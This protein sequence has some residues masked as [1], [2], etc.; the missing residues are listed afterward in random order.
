MIHLKT[1]IITIGTE[2]LLGEIVNTNAQYLAEQ[3]AN[4][5]LDVYFQTVVGDNKTRF[6]HALEI[7]AQRAKV[8]VCTGGLGPTDD[9]LTKESLAEYLDE[10]LE[11]DDAAKTKIEHFFT[12]RNVFMP[13]NNLKQ[14]L[15]ISGDEACSLANDN[16][17]AIG[18][19]I[20]KNGCYFILLPG[21]PREMKLMFQSYAVPWILQKATG[22]QRLESKMLCF[23]GIGESSVA[24][25]LHDLIKNQT[26]PSIATY[27]KE[28]EVLVRI[29]SKNVNQIAP[30]EAQIKQRLTEY[31]YAEQERTLEQV[32]IE[33][34]LEKK[35]R[36]AVA[37]SCTGG[38]LSQLI[39]SV[40]GSSA[41]LHSAVVAYTNEAKQDL[42][43]ITR[44]LL[45]GEHAPGA[46]SEQTA[47]QMAENM[48]KQCG[49][50]Y[51]VAVTGVAGPGES[52]GKP[53]G[54]V[55][56]AV[57][58]NGKSTEVYEYRTGGTR[59]IVQIRAAKYA[60]FKLCQK[61]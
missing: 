34:C 21:P 43:N 24:E 38:L 29:A 36:I 52:E 17:L 19:A 47:T 7:A 8:I 1:E 51:T 9:D 22:L 27:A 26:D 11:Y 32:L 48:L 31:L 28:G 55:Y 25:M 57:A 5:G 46:I 14:A 23:A 3:C 18:C 40:P 33:R 41:V 39:T 45:E 49:V 37:E 2:I 10:A 60:L 20:H 59:S 42:L 53:V 6:I 50:D 44:S 16:G 12:N 56:I 15:R 30:I 13:P 4:V 58:G 35:I 61:I 54:L